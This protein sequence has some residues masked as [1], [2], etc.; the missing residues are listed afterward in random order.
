ME[1]VLNISGK[2]VKMAATA[3][4]VRRY[5]NQF[6]RD[7]IL[8]LKNLQTAAINKQDK[9]EEFAVE[10]LEIFE[11]MSWCMA[12]AADNS[13]PDIDSWLDQFDTFS[14]MEVLPE[15]MDLLV[16]NMESINGKKKSNE[17][18]ENPTM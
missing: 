18:E 7:F 14:I 5:R 4:L 12:K 9:G 16:A 3:G 2:Q 10:T 15:I 1:K 8:D 17:A 11:N 13:I 6:Q